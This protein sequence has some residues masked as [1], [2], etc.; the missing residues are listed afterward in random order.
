MKPG[1]TGLQQVEG[2]LDPEFDHWVTL[3]LDY[4]DRWSL[5]LETQLLFRTIPAVI[6]GSGR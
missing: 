3:D 6:L 1:I 2:C 5:W 4:I